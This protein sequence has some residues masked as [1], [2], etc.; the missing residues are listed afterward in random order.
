MKMNYFYAALISISAV[1]L[2]SESSAS[3]SDT[4]TDAVRVAAQQ[5]YSALNEMFTGQTEAMNK[6]WSHEDDITY[7]GPDRSYLR[8][9]KKIK[10]EWEKQA[11]KKLGGK[12]ESAEMHIVVGPQIAVVSNYEIGHNK[13]PD[14]KTL[15]VKI[16]ATNIFRKE[17]GTWKMIG[18]HTDLLPFLTN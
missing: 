15:K 11:A 2:N 8:G 5:F 6:V 12:V 14:G 9:W 10:V 1:C 7:M 17:N 4:E 18:H 13:G 3:A 16:R